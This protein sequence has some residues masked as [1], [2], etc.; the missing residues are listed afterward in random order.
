MAHETPSFIKSGWKSVALGAQYSQQYRPNSPSH[1]FRWL[2]GMQRLHGAEEVQEHQ[3]EKF[4]VR[5]M[6]HIYGVD[7]RV[8]ADI[9]PYIL[10][11]ISMV[12]HT[13]VY[14]RAYMVL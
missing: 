12:H 5:C 4:H 13:I 7:V 8:P 11:Y 3:I 9:W 2:W 1:C 10:V 14:A 6:R